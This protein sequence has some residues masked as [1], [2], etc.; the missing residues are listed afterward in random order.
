M[1][2][3]RNNNVTFTK[4]IW[5]LDSRC[6][7]LSFLNMY[8]IHW[9]AICSKINRFQNNLNK[10]SMELAKRVSYHIASRC[11]IL[12]CKFRIQDGYRST[13]SNSFFNTP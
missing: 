3:K 5:H 13:H 8:H 4:N 1:S 6:P 9:C 10:S 2:I 12:R 11:T 7:S